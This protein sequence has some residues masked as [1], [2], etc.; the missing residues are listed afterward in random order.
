MT[1]FKPLS[2]ILSNGL[3]LHIYFFHTSSISSLTVT[4]LTLPMVTHRVA[5]SPLLL[6]QVTGIISYRLPVRFG[7][8]RFQRSELLSTSI[9]WTPLHETEM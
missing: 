7:S 2:L 4:A 5:D 6:E 1:E 9:R 3:Q 8:F